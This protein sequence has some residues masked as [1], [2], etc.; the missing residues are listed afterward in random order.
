A[1]DQ[2]GETGASDSKTI[3]V[4]DVA[5]VATIVGAPA[6]SPRGTPIALT[7]TIADPNPAD[8]A[9]GFTYAWSVTKDG[10]PF[11]TG[12]SAGFTF[13]PVASGTY[14]VSLAATDQDG[15]TGPS[16]SQTIAVITANPTASVSGDST[17]VRGEPRTFTL[18]AT[19]PSAAATAA[20][21]T[22]LVN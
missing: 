20:G 19:D 10:Q 16:T 13:T 4:T 14:V 9:A 7:S 2:D 17:G 21:F 15:E 8:V 12:A 6:T 18:S 22:F 11:A 1:T 3:T 5:P